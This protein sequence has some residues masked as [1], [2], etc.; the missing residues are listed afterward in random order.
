MSGVQ[1]KD[2]VL[3]LPEYLRLIQNGANSHCYVNQDLYLQIEKK[4]LEYVL[5]TF[6]NPMSDEDVLKRLISDY[7]FK[8]GVFGE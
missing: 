5:S 2:V 8:K 1:V 6:E 4:I 3:Q 7:K